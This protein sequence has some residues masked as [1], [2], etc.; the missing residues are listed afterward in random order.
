MSYKLTTELQQAPDA[1]IVDIVV[2]L[3]DWSDK[4]EDSFSFAHE[5]EGEY[6]VVRKKDGSL[7]FK[8]AKGFRV[9]WNR[10]TFNLMMWAQTLQ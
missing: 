4:P 3:R 9:W 8:T 10:L 6:M 5:D 1:G 7:A 2:A